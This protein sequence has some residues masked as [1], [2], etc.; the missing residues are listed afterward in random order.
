MKEEQ[1]V[2][3]Q[4]VIEF[5]Q[6]H[7]V[8][9]PYPGTEGLMFAL[10]LYHEFRDHNPYIVGLRKV[11]PKTS[12]SYLGQQV[13]L[14]YYDVYL[15]VIGDQVYSYY[16]HGWLCKLHPNMWLDPQYFTTPKYNVAAFHN[17]IAGLITPEGTFYQDTIIGCRCNIEA[18]RR[19]LL[20]IHY[21]AKSRRSCK[22]FFDRIV[23]NIIKIVTQHEKKPSRTSHRN[24]R[25][26]RAV[27]TQSSN[28]GYGV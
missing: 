17:Q 6:H 27:Q 9:T 25:L 3:A 7:K 11:T 20:S 4:R 5:I 22:E 12:V 2:V 19:I 28:C 26:Y 1:D 8:N 18:L 14:G 23:N 13:E 10:E 16:G 21:D 24:R 15:T